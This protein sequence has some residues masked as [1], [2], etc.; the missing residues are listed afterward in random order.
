MESM[1]GLAT[2]RYVMFEILGCIVIVLL[3]A[4]IAYNGGVKTFWYYYNV[5]D[6]K[7]TKKKK[8]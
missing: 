7:W 2:K 4:F 6:I 5:G 1:E 8:K 3:F